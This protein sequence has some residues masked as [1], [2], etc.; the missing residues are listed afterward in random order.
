MGKSK[1]GISMA[2]I[3]LLLCAS[4]ATSPESESRRQAVEADIK[5]ILS[6]PL[7]VAEFGEN[8]RCLGGGDYRNFRVLDDWHLVFEGRD[9]KLWINTLRARCPD[10]R[11]GAIIRVKSTAMTRICEMDSFHA[12][13]WFEWPWYRRYPWRWGTSWGTGMACTLGEFQPVTK[14][15]VD[16]I[17]AL[18]RSR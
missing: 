7:N 1:I 5:A 14:E 2:A 6:E 8:R 13:D 15:Q 4:C 9:G 10:L 18:L 17:E 3:I 16:E 11:N 12:S